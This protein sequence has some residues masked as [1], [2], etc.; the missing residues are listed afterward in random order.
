MLQGDIIVVAVKDAQPLY[1]LKDSTG[2]KG[3]QQIIL[4][5][6]VVRTTKPVRKKGW[7]IY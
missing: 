1:G 6:V 3:P 5:A 7:F 2:K 4:R